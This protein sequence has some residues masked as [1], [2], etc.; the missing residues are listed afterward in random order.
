MG[1]EDIG[2]VGIEFDHLTV[3]FHALAECILNALALGN[4][5]HGER[6]AD[7]FADFIE[8][9]LAR[10]QYGG[11][12]AAMRRGYGDL[13][14]GYGL[15]SQGAKQ[16]RFHYG[17]QLGKHFLDRLSNVTLDGD[18]VH[19]GESPIYADV[20]KVLIQKAES[21]GRAVIDRLELRET[22][23]GNRF[24]AGYGIVL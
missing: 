9:R 23:R 19:L 8:G 4:V 24:E 17:K 12:F 18:A 10:K 1:I 11:L 14:I 15:A 13:H 16:M 5:G 22:L 21:D 7:D 2:Y 6:N 3:F 20:A